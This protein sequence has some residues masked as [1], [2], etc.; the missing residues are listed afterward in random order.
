MDILSLAKDVLIPV[1]VAGIAFLG[2]RKTATE[3]KKSEFETLSQEL[4]AFKAFRQL[5]IDDN[6]S[7]VK[8]L[9]EMKSQVKELD[10]QLK[11]LIKKYTEEKSNCTSCPTKIAYDKIMDKR[12]KRK[13]PIH[14]VVE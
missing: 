7:L 2:G 11:A 4:A 3:K 5:L 6:N 13:K 1:V 14:K 10:S 9:K 12:A 8:E